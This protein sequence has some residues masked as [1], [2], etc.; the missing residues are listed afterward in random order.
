[1]ALF[2][3]RIDLEAGEPVP[4]A[5]DGNLQLGPL[6]VLRHRAQASQRFIV[7]KACSSVF[8]LDHLDKT[9]VET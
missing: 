9:L 4:A 8:R 7:G 2:G 5:W 3:P 6:P 1:M